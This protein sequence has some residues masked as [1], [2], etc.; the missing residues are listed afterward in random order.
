MASGGEKASYA[1]VPV[2]TA[3][4]WL[5]KLV[6]VFVIVI[7]VVL[8]FLL[9]VPLLT[10][11]IFVFTAAVV[12]SMYTGRDPT[13]ARHALEA[14]MSFYSRGFVL[15]FDSMTGN[16]RKHGQTFAI[17]ESGHMVRMLWELVFS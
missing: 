5:V 1:P 17:P 6:S 15:I 10:R 12:A 11:M 4:N 9:W 3:A 2:G 8:G 14:A 7:W 13:H 16:L